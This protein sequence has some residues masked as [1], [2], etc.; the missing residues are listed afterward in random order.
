VD[1]ALFKQLLTLL[2]GAGYLGSGPSTLQAVINFVGGAGYLGSGPSTLQAR[3]CG[4][5]RV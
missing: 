4:L 3:W 1:Q 2:G 5:R